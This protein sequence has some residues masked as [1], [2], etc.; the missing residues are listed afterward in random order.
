MSSSHNIEQ[1]LD[2]AQ[3]TILLR[4]MALLLLCLM[5]VELI[6]GALFFYDLYRTENKILS[7]MAS[8]YQRILTY[9]SAERLNHVLEANPHR[10]LENNIAAYWSDTDTPASVTFI[11]GEPD[12]SP[13]TPLSNYIEGDKSWIQT[14]LFSPY[15]SIKIQ[16]EKQQFWLVLNNNARYSIAYNQWLMTLYALIAL[17]VIT[18]I[19]T[20]KM[21]RSAMSPLVTLG[22]LLDKLQQGKLELVDT[23]SEAPQGLSVISASVHHAVG[24]L[25]HVTT[26]LN[27]TVDAIA[28]DIRTPLA[29]ITLASQSA[30]LNNDNPQAMKDALSDCAEHAMQ[31][32]N[33]LTALM[34]LNDEITG[35]RL[36]QSVPT[37]VS[38]VIHNVANWYDD[39]AEDKQITL[40]VVASD[41]I[42]IQSDPDKLTQVL[43][44]LVDNAIKY[45][46]PHGQVTIQTEQQQNGQVDI[47]VAD[48]GI[49]IDSKYQDLVFERLYQVDTSRS[50]NSGYG[51]G[52]SFVSA[53]VENLGGTISLTSEVGVGSTFT[54]S[55]PPARNIRR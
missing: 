18:A 19:F 33:M 12:L 55:F 8:E 20:R 2:K 29:R 3:R 34:K 45:T 28:H 30:L 36:P 5:L 10:L 25:Q 16:G 11:A 1:A 49:G 15:M 32:S 26:A 13:Q 7:S 14:F 40:S 44:N 51:L 41:D 43:V 54:L 31:A 52:L 39:V 50:N 17:V 9:D 24:R 6:V 21:I 46:N 37:Q 38:E 23:P 27:T 22:D 48:T 35:K 42:V 47:Q 53:M 4:F